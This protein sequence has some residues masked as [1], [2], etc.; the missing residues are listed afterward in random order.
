MQLLIQPSIHAGDYRIAKQ[1]RKDV[2]KRSVPWR[3]VAKAFPTADS[4][5][6]YW[7][8]VEVL[9]GLDSDQ[10]NHAPHRFLAYCVERGWLKRV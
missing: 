6:S 4:V 2:R 5:V 10:P 8:L 1:P 7:A 9:G 3:K